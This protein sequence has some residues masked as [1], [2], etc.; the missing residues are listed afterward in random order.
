MRQHIIN[1]GFPDQASLLR[2][3]AE[4]IRRAMTTIRK[5]R[6]GNAAS[7]DITVNT[8]DMLVKLWEFTTLWYM[9]GRAYNLAQATAAN[10]E[11]AHDFFLTL[12]EDPSDESVPMFTGKKIIRWF[13]ALDSYI[14]DKK[15]K[16]NIPLGY[17]VRTNA[18]PPA[19]DPGFGQPS[20]G[21]DLV[22]RGRLN[23]FFYVAHGKVLF[24]IIETKTFGTEAWVLIAQFK[25][26]HDGRGAHMAL[27]G[28]CLGA[29]VQMVLLRTSEDVLRRITFDNRNRNFTFDTFIARMR[30][31][32]EQMGEDNQLSEERKVNKL[33]DAWTVS[34]LSHVGTTIQSNPELRGSFDRTVV[35]LAGE[36]TALKMKNGTR[37]VSAITTTTE[38]ADVR[39]LKQ[40]RSKLKE[41][42]RK[43]KRKSGKMDGDVPAG[44]KPATKFSK[45]NPGEYVT[46]KVWRS[47]S[48]EEQ[49]A[50][51][52]ARKQ[53]GIA[54]RAI[55][56]IATDTAEEPKETAITFAEDTKPPSDQGAAT[57]PTPKQQEEEVALAIKALGTKDPRASARLFQAP[58]SIASTQRLATHQGKTKSLLRNGEKKHTKEAKEGPKKF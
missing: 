17:L 40:L 23:G 7:R 21:E 28:Q 31:A 14:Q 49:A 26:T 43:L 47:M 55:S 25:R 15:G 20:L 12:A 36:L 41:A 2:K 30:E 16:G 1:A 58:R 29:D 54:V 51:R 19:V 52:E 57:A 44:K 34:A 46:A 10:L 35:F 56:S 39:T 5:G 42:Q 3:T 6:A 18:A 13:E 33:L 4:D 8:E 50:A 37:N 53:K 22:L 48:Q 9:T 24:K 32:F 11:L 45:K 38:S 27:K